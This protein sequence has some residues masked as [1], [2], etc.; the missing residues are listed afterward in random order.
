MVRRRGDN[1][2]SVAEYA[3]WNEEAYSMWYAENRYD[4]ENA[5]EIIEDDDDR[6]D[7]EPDPFE[8]IFESEAAAR[9]WVTANRIDDNG[10]DTVSEWGGRWFVEHYD[11]EAH[12]RNVR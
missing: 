6:R 12:K 7:Y 10:R 11:K 2:P 4:M 3:H 5:D 1:I 8:E 9:E